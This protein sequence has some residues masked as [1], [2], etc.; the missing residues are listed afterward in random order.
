MDLQIIA[1]TS[2]G[3]AAIEHVAL[4][5]EVDQGEIAIQADGKQ[6]D[7]GEIPVGKDPLD[8][9]VFVRHAD[10]T[11]G[12]QR[13]LTVRRDRTPKQI[14]VFLKSS[15]NVVAPVE[16]ASDYAKSPSVSI[17]GSVSLA[18]RIKD[19]PES[20]TYFAKLLPPDPK[21][22]IQVDGETVKWGAAERPMDLSVGDQPRLVRVRVNNS[23]DWRY[24]KLNPAAKPEPP[25]NSV[26][27]SSADGW[28]AIDSVDDL[29]VDRPQWLLVQQTF[30]G[31]KT[32]VWR[33]IIR[34]PRIAVEQRR[35]NEDWQT[36]ESQEFPIPPS[37][38]RVARSS[39]GKT[40]VVWQGRFKPPAPPQVSVIAREAGQR[41]WV[42][43][44]DGAQMTIKRRRTLQ[45]AAT[46]NG[47]PGTPLVLTLDPPALDPPSQPQGAVAFQASRDRANW[48]PVAQGIT[49]IDY[50][51]YF[52]IV[53][54]GDGKSSLAWEGR[55]DPRTAKTSVVV[56]GSQ[57]RLNW[58]AVPPNSP[59][60]KYAKYVRVVGYE[61]GGR[62]I[63]W[64]GTF[65]PAGLPNLFDPGSR[66]K[67]P[68]PKLIQPQ[69]PAP[70]KLPTPIN[71]GVLPG[72]PR[73]LPTPPVAPF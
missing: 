57:D 54:S 35:N 72:K 55:F 10:G 20:G 7:L 61:Q 21:L 23:T 33:G 36:I 52:R 5:P 60:A 44:L 37:E 4:I 30:E 27:R 73:V 40:S 3:T 43:V 58:V 41:D 12:P 18:L 42:S 69:L 31:N 49:S 13:Q 9:R 22:E 63:L 19:E 71:R 6:V 32:D 66:P 15:D 68:Q 67:L 16:V 53:S 39:G 62:T 46:T 29:D 25:R 64:A 11:H 8:L 26:W 51:T 24:A 56:E 59:L 17:D 48:K 38:L 34:P 28:Q 14:E 47:K 65:T 1:T 70:I 50:P 45:F 2:E